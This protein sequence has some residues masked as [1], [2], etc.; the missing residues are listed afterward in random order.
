LI[1]PI[2][3]RVPLLEWDLRI[4]READAVVVDSERLE[5]DLRFDS[6]APDRIHALISLFDGRRSLADA[7]AAAGVPEAVARDCAATLTQSGL[8]VELKLPEEDLPPQVLIDHLRR[9][10]PPLKQRL[11]SHPLWANLNAGTA[12]RPIFMGWL[13]ENYHF[14]EG[15]NDRLALAVASCREPGIRPF[16][17]QHY[18]EE[19]DHYEFFLKALED[20][21]VPRE[22]ARASRPLPG[23]LAVLNH[24][25]RCARRDSLE[26]AAC[27]GFLESTNEDRRVSVGFFEQLGL[28]YAK[29]RPK[30]I[31]PLIEHLRLDERYQHNT[32]VEDICSQVERIPVERASAAIGAGLLFVETLETWSTDILRSYDRPAFVLRQGLQGHRPARRPEPAGGQA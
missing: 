19:W 15:V 18:V 25:R 6:A 22:A 10:Y 20:L 21:G 26:Y 7:A 27:S 2:A 30:A 17:A 12:S 14:I 11:F 28:H 9:M 3:D 8:A 4:V 32:V 16:F 13:I 24:A 5:F 1:Q 29:E 23:T 31:R